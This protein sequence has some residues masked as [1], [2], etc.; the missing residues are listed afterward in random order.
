MD[1]ATRHGELYVAVYGV[2]SLKNRIL[3]A[4]TREKTSELQNSRTFDK[5]A[6]IWEPVH[7]SAKIVWHKH[8]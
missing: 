7:G 2:Q 8:L 4:R 1:A 3:D 6:E 5:M